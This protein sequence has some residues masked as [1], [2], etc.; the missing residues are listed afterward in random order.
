M[1]WHRHKGTELLRIHQL[2]GGKA[3]EP[4]IDVAKIDSLEMLDE[5]F[6]K[7]GPNYKR[8]D[9]AMKVIFAQL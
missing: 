8:N 5:H 4:L 2:Q 3:S 7:P 1:L 9:S 6:D